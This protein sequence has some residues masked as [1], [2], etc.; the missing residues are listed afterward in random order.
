MSSMSYSP[1][2]Y[3]AVWALCQELGSKTNS[4]QELGPETSVAAALPFLASPQLS[5]FHQLPIIRHVMPSVLSQP[6]SHCWSLSSTW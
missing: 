2:I 5:L 3:K 6:D 1:V 4:Q